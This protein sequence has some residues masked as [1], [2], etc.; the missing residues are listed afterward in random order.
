LV[1]DT[2]SK[3][4]DQFDWGFLERITGIPSSAE[5]CAIYLFKQYL[6]N[7]N[8]T[9]KRQNVLRFICGCD[10]IPVRN[11]IIVSSFQSTLIH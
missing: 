11:A 4:L 6:E 9:L 5:E 7:L 3:L 1:P 2:S 8:T 10:K